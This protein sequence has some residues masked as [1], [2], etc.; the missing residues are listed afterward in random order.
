MDKKRLEI[1]LEFLIFGIVM[2]I[3]EDTLAIIFTT[4]ATITW[5]MIGIIIII[6]IPFAIV[7]ELLIDRNPLINHELKKKK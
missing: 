3:A 7:G 2:G 1:F 4:G 6:A 5:K